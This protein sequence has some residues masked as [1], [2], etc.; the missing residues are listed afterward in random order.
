MCADFC[1]GRGEDNV[2]VFLKNRMTCVDW[3]H[4]ALN[5]DKWQTVANIVKKHLGS[6]KCREFRDQLRY[7][8]SDKD[9]ATCG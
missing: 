2:K 8:W 6:V 7:F 9:S 5:R 1:F 3:I 4:L